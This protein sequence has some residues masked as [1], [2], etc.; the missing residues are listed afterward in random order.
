MK[1]HSKLKLKNLSLTAVGL[2]S[3]LSSSFSY[4]MEDRNLED[5]KP[6]SSFSSIPEFSPYDPD[7]KLLR[8]RG[9]EKNA[10]LAEKFKASGTG[11]PFPMRDTLHID[12]LRGYLKKTYA[13]DDRQ[14]EEKL[15]PK[16]V[17]SWIHSYFGGDPYFTVH[18]YRHNEFQAARVHLSMIG[19][20]IK[21]ESQHSPLDALIALR[22]PR[23]EEIRDLDYRSDL[24]AFFGISW[25]LLFS[26]PKE[27][28]DGS[29]LAYKHI[30]NEMIQTL[31]QS[32]RDSRG[33][34]VMLSHLGEEINPAN[35][36]NAKKFM[37]ENKYRY[38]HQQE[39]LPWVRS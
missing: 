10:A 20:E 8:S 38:H 32:P 7:I 11:I 33:A 3:I 28:M 35:I 23:H 19:F 34:V 31:M 27:R 1:K 29:F 36:E 24:H 21:P 39:L 30:T 6:L 16:V 12:C 18:N 26:P 22:H 5:S 17:M 9:E 25:G 13:L 14:V 2:L 15:T 37:E 4:G